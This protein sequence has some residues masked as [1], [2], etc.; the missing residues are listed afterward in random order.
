VKALRDSPS[1]DLR[2]AAMVEELMAT[3]KPAEYPVGKKSA[4]R[5]QLIRD[6]GALGDV[7]LKPA[8]AALGKAKTDDQRQALVSVVG[9]VTTAAS[10]RTL[11]GLLT[12][13][14][15]AAR[16]Q[17]IVS[18]TDRVAVPAEKGGSEEVI[19]A[20]A[21]VLPGE[22]DVNMRVAV[23]ARMLGALRPIA[24]AKEPDPRL[25]AQA[26]ELLRERLKNDTA[27]EVRF[28]AACRLT[29]VGDSSGLAELKK[30]GL[31][32]AEGG[33]EGKYSL[34]LLVPALE[35]ATGEA[36]GLVPMDPTLSSNLRGPNLG[37]DRKATLEKVAAWIKA[38]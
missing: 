27:D 37:A 14:E 3:S 6:I 31:A 11:I 26:K 32:L 28:V 22:K 24:P 17:A 15:D 23:C 5:R 29:E 21:R 34:D 19:P 33:G 10:T 12:E 2:A 4:E 36:F 16:R 30:A 1:A 20:L 8:L 35:R 9:A 38:H 13:K 25:V 7:A 18:L